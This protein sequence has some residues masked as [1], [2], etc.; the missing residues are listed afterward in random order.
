MYG[1]VM[2]PYS[3]RRCMISATAYL[4][5]VSTSS[6]LM[7][8]TRAYNPK[9]RREGLFHFVPSGLPPPAPLTRAPPSTSAR[10]RRSCPTI[11]TELKTD[12][13]V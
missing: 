6:L 8:R 11:E 10:T 4:L 3:C 2:G 9:E 12:M 5:S 1:T 13:W 7:A